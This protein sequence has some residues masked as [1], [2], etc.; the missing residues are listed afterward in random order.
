LQIHISDYHCKPYHTYVL[1]LDL[2]DSL[3]TALHEAHQSHFTTQ[4]Y[5][6]TLK[7]PSIPV[8]SRA[9]TELSCN[10]FPQ[11]ASLPPRKSFLSSGRISY[12]GIAIKRQE[13]GR[14]AANSGRQN[15]HSTNNNPVLATRPHIP[16]L[17]Y[18]AIG[19]DQ[20]RISRNAT[21]L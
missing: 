8:S 4:L 5:T 17:P 21:G 9:R 19:A 11:V 15:S 1:S 12:L 10:D 14:T 3:T 20:N 13:A 6:S 16:R 18:A 2:A 7:C